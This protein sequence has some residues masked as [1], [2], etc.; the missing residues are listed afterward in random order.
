[1]NCREPCVHFFALLLALL[2]LIL[3][4][5]LPLG[6]MDDMYDFIKNMSLRLDEL[7]EVSCISNSIWPDE[8]DTGNHHF[9]WYNLGICNHGHMCQ[10]KCAV[11]LCHGRAANLPWSC[12]RLPAHVS[13]LVCSNFL[14]WQSCQSALILQEIPWKLMM[15]T[16]KFGILPDWGNFISIMLLVILQISLVGE[17]NLPDLPDFRMQNWQYCYWVIVWRLYSLKEGFLFN[18]TLILI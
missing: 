6:L 12:R 9:E 18:I 15:W 10:R 17:K 7:E 11:T 1:M 14:L 3:F 2:K 16:H 13:M 5:D 4:Q 8:A